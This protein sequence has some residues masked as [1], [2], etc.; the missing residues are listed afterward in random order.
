MR[1]Q[2]NA[3]DALEHAEGSAPAGWDAIQLALENATSDYGDALKEASAAMDSNST[4][5]MAEGE[6]DLDSSISL[7][8]D[9]LSRARRWYKA[10]GG[11]PTDLRSVESF[12]SQP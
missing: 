7:A 8:T 6:N 3:N 9:A 10:H 4:A 11:D 2:Q 5:Q 12:A 1:A